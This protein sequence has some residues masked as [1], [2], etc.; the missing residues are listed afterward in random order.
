MPKVA[1]PA[2][3]LGEFY[4]RYLALR[5]GAPDDNQTV[6]GIADPFDRERCEA[7]I[8]Y[9]RAKTQIWYAYALKS[10]GAEHGAAESLPASAR[11]K[12]RAYIVNAD[13]RFD[14]WHRREIQFPALVRG[15]GSKELLD[16]FKKPESSQ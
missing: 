12:A 16:P 15:N 2:P 14:A 4:T 1:F 9:Q 11:E 6:E 13:D 10:F 5:F 8:A 7:R 3:S